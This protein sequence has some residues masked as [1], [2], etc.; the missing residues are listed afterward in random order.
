[1]GYAFKNAALDDI[2]QHLKDKSADLRE[3]AILA[4]MPM[5]SLKAAEVLTAHLKTEKAAHIQ[6]T[7]KRV[8]KSIKSNHKRAQIKSKKSNN[9]GGSR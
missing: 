9:L 5:S 7:I 8:T 3:D 4:L 6:L 2:A 1:M